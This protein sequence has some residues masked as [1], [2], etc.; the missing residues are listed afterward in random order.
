MY[1]Q[2]QLMGRITREHEIRRSQN[3]N[4]VLNF[5]LAINKKYKDNEEVVYINCV[6]FG[7]T[8]ELIQQ[9]T[10]KGSLVFVDGELN[11]RK[12]VD[13]NN[14]TQYIT[15]VIVR[16]VLFLD[17]REKTEPKIET[18]EKLKTTWDRPKV[19]DDPDLPF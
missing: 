12:Y 2:A 7:K 8:A 15:E 5:S 6:A 17:K 14:V 4:A 10:T 16:T 3:D 9:Y 1:N 13:K 11:S 19:V 18:V